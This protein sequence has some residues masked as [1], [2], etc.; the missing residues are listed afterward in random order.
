MKKM[1]YKPYVPLDDSNEF[2]PIFEAFEEINNYA[3]S[4]VANMIMTPE[5]KFIF[6]EQFEAVDKHLTENFPIYASSRSKLTDYWGQSAFMQEMKGYMNANRFGNRLTVERLMALSDEATQQRGSIDNGLIAHMNGLMSGFTPKE[7]VLVYEMFAE[8]PA[9]HLM[10]EDGTLRKLI[11]GTITI[12]SVIDDTTNNLDA[13][14]MKIVENMVAILSGTEGHISTEYDAYNL[15]TAGLSETDKVDVG[16]AVAAVMIKNNKNHQ[17]GFDLMK[18]NAN[19]YNLIY[20]ASNGLKE[21]FNRVYDKNGDSKRFREN[22][23]VD[24]FEEEFDLEAITN[25]EFRNNIFNEDSGWVVLRKPTSR[26]YGIVY[27]K[28]KDETW[29]DGATTS[30]SYKN[31]DVIVP[32]HK[33]KTNMQNII[34]TDIGRRNKRH[35]LV[36]TKAEKESLGLR[37]NIAD[38]IY[39]SHSR[40]V[41]IEETQTGRDLLLTAEF[42]K[43]IGG[44]DALK[45]YDRIL[46]DMDPS[47]RK[48]MLGFRDSKGNPLISMD[49][50]TAKHTSGPKKNQYVYANIMKYYKVPERASSVGGFR[51]NF[52]L[53]RIDAAPWLMGY[54][55]PIIFENYPPARKAAYVIRQLVKNTKIVWTALS[56]TKIFN[57]NVSNGLILAGYDVPPM[58]IAKYGKQIWKEIGEFEKLRME[59]V[60]AKVHGDKVAE[61]RINK[62]ILNHP[63]NMMLKNGMLQSINIELYQ[64]DSSVVTGLQKDIEALLN[65][66][67]LLP[68]GKR[69]SVF[70]AIEALQNFS[71]YGI[72]SILEFAGEKTQNVDALESLGKQ[73]EAA[74][75]KIGNLKKEVANGNDAAMAQFVSEFLMTPTSEAVQLGSMLVQRADIVARGILIRHLIDSGVSEE[76][77]LIVATDAFINYKQNMPKGLKL[78]SDYGILLFPSFWMRAHKVQLALIKK[79]P[80]TVIAG[81]AIASILDV[82]VVSTIFDANILNKVDTGIFHTPP[83]FGWFQ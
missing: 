29:Q 75:N 45:Q 41:E 23:I 34:S 60:K 9:F 19:V 48:W 78:V 68:D 7:H 4:A 3:S 76:E 37:K 50:I 53:V 67:I 65:K 24:V 64:R 10:D 69:S 58:K 74:G 77:A 61:V 73:L 63:M 31:T 57:D 44:I 6:G 26:T 83:I 47:E 17:A 18:K 70:T 12:D 36:L 38:A 52:D 32:A 35:K 80:A 59:Q 49:K 33:Q 72:D 8:T 66:W 79:N 56:P 28:S 39:R 54:K 11:E 2:T 1:E 43:K 81:G 22:L 13:N 15:D 71:G 27:R 20:D 5:N 82:H 42:T 62:A 30:V 21:I 55:D 40:M 14:Q 25:E 51:H 46:G 16:K